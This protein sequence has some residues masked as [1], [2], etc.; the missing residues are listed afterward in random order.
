MEQIEA[1][2]CIGP[3][4]QDKDIGM[5]ECTQRAARRLSPSADVIGGTDSIQLYVLSQFLGCIA[6]D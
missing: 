3:C 4:N 2:G 5:V 1:E 6:L